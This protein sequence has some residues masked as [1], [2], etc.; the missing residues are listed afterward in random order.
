MVRVG[1]DSVTL[2]N[3]EP[4]K[5]SRNVIDWW[6]GGNFEKRWKQIKREMAGFTRHDHVPRFSRVQP[7]E[8]LL[9][10][11]MRCCGG[12][13]K[14]HIY[15]FSIAKF[16][17][18]LEPL[19]IPPTILTCIHVAVAQQKKSKTDQNFYIINFICAFRA[20]ILLNAK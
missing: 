9:A 10:N 3:R 20:P 11:A 17:G 7:P 6:I 8:L 15:C 18:I 14:R 13:N 16:T 4:V 12:W 19:M 5:W 1:D 2:G